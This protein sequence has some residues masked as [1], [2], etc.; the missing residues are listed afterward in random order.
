MIFIHRIR[1]HPKYFLFQNKFTYPFKNGSQSDIFDFII[2][3]KS[4]TK[5]LFDNRLS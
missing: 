5:Y 3:I 2:F 1:Y 4:M